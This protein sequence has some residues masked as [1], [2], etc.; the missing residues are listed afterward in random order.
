MIK[1]TNDETKEMSGGSVRALPSI[2]EQK[3]IAEKL[4]EIME[5]IDEA[6]VAARQQL[7][8]AKS[9]RQAYL[10]QAFPT[11]SLPNGWHWKKIGDVCEVVNGFGFKEELQGQKN[12]EYPFYKVND[13][14]T[15]STSIYVSD[16]ANRVDNVILKTLGAK[17]YPIG[18]VIFPKVGG[19][20][21][22]NKK[23]ILSKEG[24]FDNNIMGIVPNT[25]N[26]LFLY[27][28]VVT[29]D[30]KCYS[31]TQALPSIRK[32]DISD[33][34]LPLPP[35]E[36][37]KRIA[38]KLKEIMEQID[39][40]KVAARQ[41]L[42]LAKSLRQAY[43]RQAFPT[44][45]LPKG[46]Q[47]VRLGE[48]SDLNPSRPKIDREDDKLTSFI[49]MNSIDEKSG[50]INS[51]A[52]KNYSEV[53]KGYTY[54]EEGDVLFAKITP[55]M[56]NG[57]HA[58]ASHLIN[59]FGFGSTEFHV[60]KPIKGYA[61]P[62]WILQYIRQDIILNSAKE[63]FQGSAGQQRVHPS[64]LEKLII[65]LPPLEE[66]KRIA[67]WLSEKM[68]LVDKLA[69]TAQAQLGELELLPQT[70]LKMAF[71]GRLFSKHP[72]VILAVQPQQVD[73]GLA[74]K[75][76]AVASYIVSRLASEPTFGRVKFVKMMYFA[77]KHI[78]IE[79]EGEYEKKAAGPFDSQGMGDLEDFAKFHGFFDRVKKDNRYIYRVGK[80]IKG[81][82]CHA[83]IILGD[84]KDEMDVMLN[85]FSR[86]DTKEIELIATIYAVWNDFFIDGHDPGIDEI[87][88]NVWS[89][90]EAKSKFTKSYIKSSIE[91]LLKNEFIPKGIGPKTVVH[92]NS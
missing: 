19:A 49:P 42:E 43:L 47:R 74:F 34:L 86:M 25:V 87:V 90:H 65:P 56:Q 40:A 68:G 29:I 27:F 77:E 37:Q 71:S 7:E 53:K 18:T 13:M 55:C 6:K 36:E 32:S 10:R 24:S 61:T 16:A 35:I 22:T 48:I 3:R 89:W 80:N 69:Q 12:L 14:N 20:L 46:W 15:H 81:V 91:W 88:K 44:D 5:Q 73:E 50:K 26:S 58:I 41:Q 78:G 83:E 52:I 39:E 21:L 66:Q 38:E 62:Y 28:F 33:I 17:T 9:L 8:L 82:L 23:R 57:K 30:L 63:S 11:D 70:Y 64:F 67:T 51:P 84:K 31:N 72:R 92:G 2:E 85:L 76:A 1:T 45:P 54:F 75:R 60:I 4:K 59:G 79:L